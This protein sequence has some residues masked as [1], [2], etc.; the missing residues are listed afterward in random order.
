MGSG[1]FICIRKTSLY[2]KIRN[3]SVP[4]LLHDKDIS[5]PCK[6]DYGARTRY[7]HLGKVALYQ[8]S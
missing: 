7:L 4:D 6:A 3:N 2:E 5:K 1:L 8:M